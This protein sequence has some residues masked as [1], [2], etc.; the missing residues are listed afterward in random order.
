MKKKRSIGNKLARVSSYQSQG[1]ALREWCN[2]WKTDQRKTIATLRLAMQRDSHGDI[3]YMLDQLDG[4]TKKRFEGL[5]NTVHR[6][7]SPE[8]Q[9]KDNGEELKEGRTDV[10]GKKLKESPEDHEKIMVFWA[11]DWEKK[12]SDHL[13]KLR[14]AAERNDHEEMRRIS[15]VLDSMTE[16]N[17]TALENAFY[18]LSNPKY[19]T[20]PKWD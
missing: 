14:R 3:M 11:G 7:T 16:S 1:E 18:I 12:Q 15:R 5:Y 20:A 17:F 9:L 4:M 6:I 13:T 2:N 8:R 19:K 10:L